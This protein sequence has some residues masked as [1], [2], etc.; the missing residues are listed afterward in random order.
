MQAKTGRTMSAQNSWAR[1]ED[2]A[3]SDEERNESTALA[4]L[5]KQAPGCEEAA[6][7]EFQ[8]AAQ[9]EE[10]DCVTRRWIESMLLR[11]ELRRNYLIRT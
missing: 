8:D 1:A 3:A 2:N 7:R 9:A 5:G 6:R 4:R 11:G 10:S